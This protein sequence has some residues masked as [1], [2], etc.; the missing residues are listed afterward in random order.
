M[1][2]KK[3]GFQLLYFISFCCLSS[4]RG[5]LTAEF[6]A[7]ACTRHTAV[8]IRV[9]HAGACQCIATITLCR[10]VCQLR[11]NY[12]DDTVT[13]LVCILNSKERIPSCKTKRSA[14]VKTDRG[15]SSCLARQNSRSG[16]I[17]IC[18]TAKVN[19]CTIHERV[20]HLQHPA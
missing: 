6:R 19:L 7:V 1:Y 15:A 4:T 20:G 11:P 10:N 18:S 14:T 12:N 13:D 9:K 16:A 3:D 2:T 8:S 17:R 5:F